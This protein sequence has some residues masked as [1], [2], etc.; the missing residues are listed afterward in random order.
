[1]NLF[2]QLVLGK[3]AEE[4][5]PVVTEPQTEEEQI[6]A[7]VDELDMNEL[8]N[9]ELLEL[10]EQAREQELQLGEEEDEGMEEMGAGPKTASAADYEK[11]AA[12]LE[13]AQRFCGQVRAN[14]FWDELEKLAQANG[15][16]DEKDEKKDEKKKKE[17]MEA[18]K[19]ASSRFA[20]ALRIIS[21]GL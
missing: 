5:P 3:T 17:E 8:S 14:A 19:E 6:Q 10:A 13:D 2:E 15:M 4:V 11:L 16:S 12:A 21:E 7:L 9:E 20:T 1:M 18:Q